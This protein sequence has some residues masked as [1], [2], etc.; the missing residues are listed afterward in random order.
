MLKASLSGFQQKCIDVGSAVLVKPIPVLRV[1]A[2]W[3]L[4]Q[5]TGPLR[6]LFYLLLV[7]VPRL[8][9]TRAKHEDIM[10]CVKHDTENNTT[11][12]SWRACLCLCKAV[13]LGLAKPLWVLGIAP[14]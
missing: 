12:T 11:E 13:H 1:L 6:A 8:L 5:A 4:P 14:F 2:L 10:A 3:T 7:K 9:K